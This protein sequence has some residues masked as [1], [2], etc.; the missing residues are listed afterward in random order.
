MESDWFRTVPARYLLAL[1]RHLE[2]EGV[3]TSGSLSKAGLK[4]PALEH[5][6]A[7]IN[8]DS[9]TIALQD[10][11][12]VSRR[13]DLGFELGLLTNIAS[14]EMVGQM[15]L[16]APSLAEGLRRT[17]PYFSLLTPSFR[18]QY[19]EHTTHHV[20]T[21]T[22]ARPLPYDMAVMGLE[23]LA[24]A[25]HRL[26][27][28]LTQEKSVP[29]HLNV[30]WPA[31]AH[32]ARYSSLKGLKVNF[33]T[34]DEPRYEFR[35]PPSVALAPLP[36]ADARALQTAERACEQLMR[37]LTANRS[38]TEWVTLMLQSSEGH[39]PNQD[40]LA[41]LVNVSPRTLAR[42]LE[43]EGWSYRDLSK[44][45]RHERAKALLST[46]SLAVAEIAR[47]LGYSDAANFVRAFRAVE[48]VSPGHFRALPQVKP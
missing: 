28:F 8:R 43:A 40:E 12:R 25:T 48:R 46:S 39:F 4:L 34:S 30:S 7:R 15:M 32:V 5:A 36:M 45:V 16:S 9:L 31:P 38:W 11:S 18:E 42:S 20:L 24:V 22:P 13:T 17:A 33:G 21:C 37:N 47:T 1:V 6:E 3:S 10:L 27:L 2:A 23:T 44:Q 41:G 35:L 29:C 26:I 19:V 14:A